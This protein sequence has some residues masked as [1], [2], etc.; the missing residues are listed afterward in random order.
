VDRNVA[1][2]KRLATCR[3]NQ[4]PRE[5][6]KL[7]KAN[8]AER[9]GKRSKHDKKNSNDLLSSP[10]EKKQDPRSSARRETKKKTGEPFQNDGKRGLRGGGKGELSRTW[11]L[12]RGSTMHFLRKIKY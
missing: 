10:A 8:G 2:C 6:E 7:K 12:K 9:I 11:A 3:V 4:L 5:R 1:L